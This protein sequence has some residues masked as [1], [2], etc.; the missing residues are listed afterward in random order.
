MVLGKKLEKVFDFLGEI[1]AVLTII[2]VAFLYIN[3]TFKFITDQN[4]ITLLYTIREY[5]ILGTIIVVGIEFAVK[6][7]FMFFVL[8]CVVATV[9]VLFSFFPDAIPAFLLPQ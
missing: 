1:L 7:S 6:R 5:A 8:F 4:L 3:G 2:L 9:A